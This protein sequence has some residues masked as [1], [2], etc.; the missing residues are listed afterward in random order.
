MS[1]LYQYCRIIYT[2]MKSQGHIKED[3]VLVTDNGQHIVSAV[4]QTSVAH[5]P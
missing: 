4:N 3:H 5:I 2:F 1:Q